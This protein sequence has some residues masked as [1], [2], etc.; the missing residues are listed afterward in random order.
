MQIDV[1]FIEKA[2]NE[3]DIIE[4]YKKQS[5]SWAKIYE[6]NKFNSNIAKAQTKGKN[7]AR[8]AYDEAYLPLVDGYCIGL[9]E[10][11]EELTSLEFANLLKNKN[12][13][14]FFIGGAYGFSENFKTKMN[15]LVSL[16]RL[17][18]PH[19]VAKL[20]LFEQI[21]R[22]LSINNNHPYHK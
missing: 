1:Y 20:I 17:T 4:K 6:I 22:G 2:K 3:F 12:K 13:I 18:M 21:Y 15:K 14:S 5:S 19:K 16:S 8:K 9:D 7:E 11:G 10:A